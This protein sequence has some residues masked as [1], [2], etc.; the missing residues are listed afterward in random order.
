[1]WLLQLV[2]LIAVGTIAKSALS[3]AWVVV[4]VFQNLLMVVLFQASFYGDKI[5]ARKQRRND[6]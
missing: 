1:L 3:N 5:L 4:V 2:L 6:C